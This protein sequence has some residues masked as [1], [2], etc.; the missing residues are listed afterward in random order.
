MTQFSLTVLLC[1]R[2]DTRCFV[3]NHCSYLL[4]YLPTG[5]RVHSV[6]FHCSCWWPW[7]TADDQ[8]ISTFAV[9]KCV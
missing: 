6:D 8:C 2:S 3:V 5:S 9:Y 4:T 1:P 7:T